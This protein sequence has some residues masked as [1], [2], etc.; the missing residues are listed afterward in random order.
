MEPSIAEP[1]D[2]SCGHAL[3][4]L[5]GVDLAELDSL[6]DSALTR[7]LQRICAEADAPSLSV[8]RFEAVI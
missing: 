2:D 8:A 5:R 4:D 7:A 6:E 1:G 3:L